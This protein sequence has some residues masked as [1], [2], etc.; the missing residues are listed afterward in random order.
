MNQSN[1]PPQWKDR[2]AIITGGAEGLGFAVAQRLNSLGTR[3]ALLDMN[4]A[5]L[6]V[7]VVLWREKGFDRRKMVSMLYA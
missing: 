2:T 6:G 3:V 5:K 7:A 4:A 1:T